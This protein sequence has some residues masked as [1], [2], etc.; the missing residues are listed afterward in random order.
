MVMPSRRVFNQAVR[1]L[2]ATFA[3]GRRVLRVLGNPVQP[4][5]PPPAPAARVRLDGWKPVVSLRPRTV[6]ER[7]DWREWMLWRFVLDRL[8]YQVVE[9]YHDPYEEEGA[10]G[11]T[12][13]ITTIVLRD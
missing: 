5:N 4:S 10:T 9:W 12:A 11:R 7:R 1:E 6:N 8:G 3:V 13:R 2:V